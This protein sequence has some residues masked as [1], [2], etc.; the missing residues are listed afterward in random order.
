MENPIHRQ[1][2]VIAF[3]DTD[4][5]G[6]MHFPNIF[7][8]VEAAEHA[9]L[10]A[11]GVLVF[12]RAEGG[13]PRVKVGCEYKRPFLAGDRYEVL[14]EV[15]NIG[16]SSITWEFQVLDGA[17]AIAA[18]GGMTNVRVNHVGRPVLITDEE[19]ARLERGIHPERN[20]QS[21]E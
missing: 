2:G 11:R 21:E 18:F 1:A 6:W 20:S 10:R 15:S 12:D 9:C 16:A 8:Y 14:L 7:K 19:R 4:A 17:G 13:W 5:S 3:A